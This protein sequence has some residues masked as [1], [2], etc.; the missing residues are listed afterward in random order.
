[1]RDRLRA[2][3]ADLAQGDPAHDIG[4]L[5]R[6]WLNA[7]LIATDTDADHTVLLA[8]SYLH[9]LVN[10]PKDHPDR[11]QASTLSAQEALPHLR[12]LDLTPAQIKITQHAITA[13]SFSARIT[14]TTPEAQILQD[15]DRIDALGAIGLARC[16]AVSG[17][18]GRA[19]FDPDDPF[20]D[21]RPL[22]DSRFTIDHFATK[23]LRLPD[24]MQTP[25]GRA[26]ADQ[27]AD[28]LRRY[29]AD[30]AQELPAS[31]G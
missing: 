1:M 16:F 29:L 31:S 7:Q 28:V 2:L 5:D 21:H 20:A 8:A 17:A 18:L 3:V 26:L 11:A 25:R 27:R 19:L 10:L 23:L 9:D 22:D 6:V 30:L 14:P 24:T 15:A 4:H 12:A 13:H